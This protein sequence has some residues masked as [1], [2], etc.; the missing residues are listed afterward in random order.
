MEESGL[1][2]SLIGFW[3]DVARLRR[4]RETAGH[5]LFRGDKGIGTPNAPIVR[6]D[7]NVRSWWMTWVRLGLYLLDAVSLRRVVKKALSSSADLVIF[8]RYIYDELANLTLHTA[9]ARIY[10]AFLMKLVPKPHISYLLDADPVQAF[11]RKPEYPLA[12]LFA[13]RA[14]YLALSELA[15]GMTVI[16]PMPIRETERE[17]MKHALSFLASDA[18]R[19][20]QKEKRRSRRA[21]KRFRVAG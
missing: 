5:T 6:R 20:K 16:P 13:S 21:D 15:G 1:R 10:I 11:A 4:M 18:S 2:V 19:D 8:D 12:F 14:S 7:K 17:I 9:A 3:D